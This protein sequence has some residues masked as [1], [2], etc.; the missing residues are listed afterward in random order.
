MVQLPEK[1]CNSLLSTLGLGENVMS[2]SL[3]V[4]HPGLRY[5]TDETGNRNY[6]LSVSEFSPK[7]LINLLVGLLPSS[8]SLPSNIRDT[9]N[10]I[11]NASLSLSSLPSVQ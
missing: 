3:T 5:A 7:Q 6:E 9:I 11:G 1:C 8:V 4:S 2:Q 10:S